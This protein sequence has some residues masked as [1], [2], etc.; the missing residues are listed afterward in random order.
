M[1]DAPKILLPYQQEWFADQ[2]T[3][4]VAEK[5]RRTGITWT[6]AARNVLSCARKGRKGRNI[7]YICYDKEIT[8]E[9]IA[10][11]AQWCRDF[12]LAMELADI[13][14]E[15]LRGPERDSCLA[16]M[17]KMASGHSIV[18][19]SGNPRSLR[20]RKGDVVVDEAAFHDDLDATLKSAN[21]LSIW[22]GN[23]TLIS[24]HNGEGSAFNR[25][26]GEIRSKEREEGSVHRIPFMRAIDEGLYKRMCLLNGEEWTPKKEQAFVQ[27]IYNQYLYDSAE[28]LDCIPTR[29][30]GLYIPGPVIEQCQID[31]DVLELRCDDDF[32]LQSATARERFVDD[33][34]REELAPH[35]NALPKDCR[36]FLGQDF[37][38]ISDVSVLMPLTMRR[39]MVRVA[40]WVVEM[41]NVPHD[42]QYQIAKYVIGRLPRFVSAAFDATGNGESLAE[43][44][45][46]LYNHPGKSIKDASQP[47]QMVK[48]TL[49]HYNEM[50]PVLRGALE[51]RRLLIPRDDNI[52]SDLRAIQKI[53]GI[54]RLPK[55][56]T[57][58]GDRHGDSAI[59][60]MLGYYMTL[61]SE[62][63]P[64]DDRGG[65][66]CPSDVFD[67]EDERPIHHTAGFGLGKGML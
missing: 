28:E 2:S 37:G 9:Y 26:V 56:K 22:G 38:R 4:R 47:I 64:S 58:K 27:K 30:G 35:V 50:M 32:V 33:W 23:V 51:S 53:D 65:S 31:G 19:L 44:I 67:A 48:L 59:A 55:H 25:I 24:T 45:A 46:Q 8:R 62:G 16:F 29:S 6:E 63:L 39:D 11:C 66:V 61:E 57:G 36:H 20:G 5:G 40:P 43:R 10:A 54:P 3:F 18:A 1:S 60:A 34:I 17:I 41:V 21:A 13:S 52:K 14:S 49:N 15:L 7:S 42:Q 12:R